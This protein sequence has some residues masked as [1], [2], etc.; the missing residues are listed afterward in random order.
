MEI[1]DSILIHDETELAPSFRAEF[2]ERLVIG[3]RGFGYWCWKPQIIKQTLDRVEYGDGVLYLDIGCHLNPGG[4]RRLE[5]YFACLTD[6][7]PL[8]VFQ[9]APDEEPFGEPNPNLR[10]MSWPLSNWTKGDLIEHFG[11]RDRRDILDAETFH[12]GSFLL[13]KTPETVKL[14]DDW[15]ETFRRDWSLIDDSP[16]VAPNEPG[17]I[18]HRHDQAIFALLCHRFPNKTVISGNE[19]IYPKPDHNGLWFDWD[20]LADFPIHAR[21]DR[22]QMT[23]WQKA[24]SAVR[25]LFG[26]IFGPFRR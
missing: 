9:Q 18:E 4:R 13:R 21:R 10:K 23:I 15:I 5:E 14:I 20:K 1:F 22:R 2:A 19:T 25:S 6:E 16:S 12:A 11:I 8:L 3:S 26:P 24:Q 17:F 7:T